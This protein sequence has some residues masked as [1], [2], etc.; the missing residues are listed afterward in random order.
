MQVYANIQNP[1][2]N[3]KANFKI[4]ISSYYFNTYSLALEQTVELKIRQLKIKIDQKIIL[5]LR[6]NF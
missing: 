2:Q 1:S 4:Y 3:I 6:F 5:K